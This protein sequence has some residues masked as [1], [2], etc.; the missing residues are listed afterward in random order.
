[1]HPYIVD[2][3]DDLLISEAS[4]TRHLKSSLAFISKQCYFN[5]DIRQKIT[6]DVD[7][8]NKCCV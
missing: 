8:M 4:E 1:M 2:C 3:L 5:L 7:F 6:N